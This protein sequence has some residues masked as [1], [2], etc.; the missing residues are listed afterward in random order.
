MS[1]VS[2]EFTLPEE[3]Q[4]MELAVNAHR[5]REALLDFSET[6]LRSIVKYDS[7]PTQL[8]V[9]IEE[10]LRAEF[11]M[12]YSAA[13]EEVILLTASYL[14]DQLHESLSNNEISLY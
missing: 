6:V 1:K 7:V 2:L 11:S 4:E 14:K 5:Y 12:E 8:K 13:I 9:S 3:Q 10:V